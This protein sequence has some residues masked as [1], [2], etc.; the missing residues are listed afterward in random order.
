MFLYMKVVGNLPFIDSFCCPF[1]HVQ[2]LLD[3]IDPFLL[4]VKLVCFEHVYFQR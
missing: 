2:A 4:L 1:N 3:P